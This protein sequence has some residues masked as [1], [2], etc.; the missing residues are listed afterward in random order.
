[1]FVYL[2][3]NIKSRPFFCR[4]HHFYVLKID[5][6]ETFLDVLIR[7]AEQSYAFKT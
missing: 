5:P 4:I 6:L 3:Y 7:V 1:M 2:F